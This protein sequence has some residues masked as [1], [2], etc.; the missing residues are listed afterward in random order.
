MQKVRRFIIKSKYVLSIFLILLLPAVSSADLNI[1]V[2]PNAG[3]GDA[4]TSNIRSLCENIALHFQEQLRDEHKLNGKLTIVYNPQGPIT[5][6]RTA[7]GGHSDEYK[8]GLQVTDTYWSQ[9]SYQFGHELCHIMQ[10]HD[11]I[12]PNNPNAWFFEAICELANLW[13]IRRM[14]KTWSWRAPYENWVDYRHALKDYAD[15]WMMSRPEV[16]Y[17]GTGADWLKRWEDHSRENLNT[18]DYAKFAQLSYKFLP[19]FEEE[20]KAWNAIRQM[21]ASK[22]KM[23]EYM[24]VW[25]DTVDHEDKKFVESM[26]KEMGIS[27]TE[28][29][30]TTIDADVN[31][32]GYVDLSDVLIVRS[33]MKH[34]S[35]YN[36]DINKD[37]VTNEV[38]LLLV[39]AKA[40]EA[41]V[42]AAPTAVRRK[43]KITTWGT[44]KRR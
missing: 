24:R 30:S 36:T 43:L 9:F 1:T 21:P 39:K 32:D 22:A 42:Q 15:N 28:L 23:S 17:H 41:I 20:P 5:F 26:A 19:I 12:F 7:F 35:I 29:V 10:N 34:S 3:W 37:G 13:V 40:F 8:I 16:Q 4:P 11:E 14:A 27:V 6:Y 31:N 2:K 25:Y 44:L 33:G 18:S 38:D